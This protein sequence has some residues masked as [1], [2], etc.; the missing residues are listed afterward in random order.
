MVDWGRIA[1]G[2]ATGGLS[3]LGGVRT[4]WDAANGW[5]APD[6][7]TGDNVPKQFQDRQQILNQINSGFDRV[8]NR[9]APQVGTTQIATGPQ[10]QFRGLQVDQANRLNAIA[11]GQQM[12]PAQLAAQQAAQQAYARQVGMA[13]MMR[14]GNAP[15]AGLAAARNQ[16]S[17]AGNAAGQMQ[18]GAL[19]D[20]QAANAQLTA[21]LSQGRGADIG[22]AQSQAQLDQASKI[23]NLDAQ[24]R[25]AG[26]D[27]ASR[28]AYL[29]QLT[30]MNATELQAAMQAT[31]AGN[32]AKT[33]LLGSVLS[34]GGQLAGASMA[35][36]ERLKDNVTDARGE[37]DEMLDALSPKAW[38]Y[39]DEKHG[40]GRFNG[41]IAQDMERSEAGRR[42][43]V[44]TPEGKML[45]ANHTI[46]ALLASAAR[47]N[48][49]VRKLE[50]RDAA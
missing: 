26:M 13:N 37:V 10:D 16:V 39:K 45:D 12:G 25:Q 38:D 47:L 29:Q 35:S 21:A 31:V 23:A 5:K 28:L 48:E 4:A 49:R 50:G 30:G 1:T 44:D 34:A 11:G 18:Q 15:A 20:Q 6:F 41:I 27:D 40:Q 46:G 7:L 14:G 36:D 22:L 33:Q 9:V 8:N 19:S 17:I 2:V 3:E 42:V 43:V 24:L 32:Q